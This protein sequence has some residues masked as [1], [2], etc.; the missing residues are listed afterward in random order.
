MSD[1]TAVHKGFNRNHL[2]VMAL[3]NIIGSGIFLGSGEVISLAGPA[4]ILSYAI[5]GIIML[6]EVMLITEMCV[7]NPAPGAIRVHA[8]EVF[9]LWIGFVNGWMFWVSGVL[10]MASEVAAAA[11]FT[12]LWF[13][14]VPLWV[15]CIFY[16]AV[17]TVINLNDARGLSRIE[18]FLASIKVVALIVFVIFGILTVAGVLSYGA[19][20][21]S[22]I[23]SS[24]ETF[25]PNG[26]KG[27]MA[28][29]IMVLFSFTGTGIIGLAI[30]ETDNPE[31]N[32]PPAIYTISYTVIILYCLS[33]FFII[34]LTP[35][36]TISADSS[37]YVFIIQEIG[38]PYG[39]DILNFIVLTAALS[40]LNSAMFSASR[41]LNSLSRDGQGP[42]MFLK[43]N[44]NGVP[45]YALGL[46]SIVL[47]FTAI[48]SYI[49]P[50][51][52]FII[53]AASSGF[54]AMFNW[55]TV[56]VTHI[57]YRRKTLKEKPEKL[58][59]KVPGYPLIT[60]IELILI[61]LVFI[62]SP[63]YPGQISGLLGSIIL[64][65]LLLSIYLVMKKSKNL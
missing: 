25:M 23:F 35:W 16:A 21:P 40:G 37:P 27:V 36:R 58:K 29:M 51:K 33:I 42:Q 2:V 55:L 50:S 53:L 26:F 1:N 60:I 15:F 6:I 24:I 31:K 12:R 11:I 65:I 10:G 32:A 13:P 54:T 18:S 30:A 8:S 7:I 59:Y 3:G 61:I 41:M 56:A 38:I 62:T 63:L 64:F 52:V 4:A 20:K 19:L 57:F 46:S 17:M 47:M 48:L 28:S 43:K 14:R 22:P 9:G 39:K 44:K 34:L 49:L 45:V 5:G